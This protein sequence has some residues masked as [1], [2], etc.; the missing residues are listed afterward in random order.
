M[1]SLATLPWAK[2][3]GFGT[4]WAVTASAVSVLL[5]WWTHPTW[6]SPMLLFLILPP[7]LVLVLSGVVHRSAR[8]GVLAALI[9]A[10]LNV[11]LFILLLVLV[12]EN[13]PLLNPSR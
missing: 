8:V 4:A 3:A 6:G 9:T 5:W 1:R 13:S 11:G 12:V 10:A 7:C 2:A